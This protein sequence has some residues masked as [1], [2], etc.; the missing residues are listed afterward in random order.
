MI[1]FLYSESFCVPFT[2]FSVWNY[3][4]VDEISYNYDMRSIS[5]YNWHKDPLRKYISTNKYC[6]K[7]IDHKGVIHHY[8]FIINIHH[9][10]FIFI[11][12]GVDSL[13]WVMIPTCLQYKFLFAVRKQEF[14]SECESSKLSK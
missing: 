3:I 1:I 2:Y 4:R 13:K 9:Y 10:A 8:A 14:V 5:Q 12:F 6:Q 7:K 11:P